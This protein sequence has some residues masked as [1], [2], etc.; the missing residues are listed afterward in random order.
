[1]AALN[2]VDRSRPEECLALEHRDAAQ[3]EVPVVRVV[4]VAR[5]VKVEKIQKAPERGP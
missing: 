1:M 3:D 2:L 4:L 5:F